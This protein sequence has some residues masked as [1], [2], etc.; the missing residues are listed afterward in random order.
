MIVDKA[1]FQHDMAY[2]DFKDLLRKTTADKLLR[3]KAFDIAKNPKHDGYQRGFTSIAFKSFDK[4]T[5]GGAVKS[6][7]MTNQ[8][9]IEELQ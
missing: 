4:K 9:L 8:Q 7:I 6:E 3:D 5:S 2:K 1:C